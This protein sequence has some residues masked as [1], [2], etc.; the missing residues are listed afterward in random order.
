AAPALDDPNAGAP[1]P[2]LRIVGRTG[3]LANYTAFLRRLEASP[4]LQNV[5][6]IEA[7]T[8]IEGNRALTSFI[9]QATYSQADSSVVRTVPILE[10][11]V[12]N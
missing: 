3:D 11:V 6:P 7:K 9:I 8:V 2:S 4:W 10:S 12:E 5:L 1:L